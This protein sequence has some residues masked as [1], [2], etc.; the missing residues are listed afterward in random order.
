MPR[1]LPAPYQPG[2]H[3]S[4]AAGVRVFLHDRPCVYD[5]AGRATAHQSDSFWALYTAR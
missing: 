5:L 4:P 3:A 2:Q 1:Q